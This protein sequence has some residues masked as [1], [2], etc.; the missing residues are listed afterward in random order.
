MLSKLS[1]ISEKVL[2]VSG[3]NV[4]YV[5]RISRNELEKHYPEF[6]KYNF[7][8]V[9]ILD[10]GEQLASIENESLDF[11]IA[12]H[13]LEHCRNPILTIK[14]HI[15]KLK[16]GGV[17]FYAIPDQRNPFDKDRELTTFEHLVNDYYGKNDDFSHYE[18]F[19][20][21]WGKLTDETEIIINSKKLMEMGYRIH[22]H[23]WTSISL[24]DFINKTNTFDSAT[25][26]YE[27]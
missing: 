22:F 11:I 2:K 4:K 23:T 27:L 26:L 16:K 10:D 20:R 14:N 3:A 13:M 18:E 21:T 6:V 24:F 15:K 5:D 19:S 8:N 1:H 9:D 7:V 17:L 12:I 25:N